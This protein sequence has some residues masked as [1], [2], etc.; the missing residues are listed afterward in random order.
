MAPL[1]AR[2]RLLEDDPEGQ[3]LLAM[4]TTPP[5]AA[6]EPPPRFAVALM[7][8]SLTDGAKQLQRRSLLLH[9]PLQPPAAAHAVLQRV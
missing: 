3:R 6:G 8:C 2:L 1:V 4:A 5:C 7:D 9:P